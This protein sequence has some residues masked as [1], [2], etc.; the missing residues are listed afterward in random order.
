M[1][2]HDRCSGFLGSKL[3]WTQLLFC[4]AAEHADTESK[5]QDA[6][7]SRNEVRYT[8]CNVRKLDVIVSDV[9]GSFYNPVSNREKY[10]SY[11]LN[12]STSK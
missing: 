11:S 6:V 9:A 10:F 8:N 7:G 12:F 1:A 4:E 5:I 3:W 2:Q